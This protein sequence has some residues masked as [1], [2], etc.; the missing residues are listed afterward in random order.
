[1]RIPAPPRPLLLLTLAAALLAAGCEKIITVDLD[2]NNPQIVIEG[3]LTDAPGPCIVRVSKTGSYFSPSIVFPLVT[4]ANVTITDNTGA[5]DT[6]RE[7]DTGV[8]ASVSLRGVPGRTYTLRVAA[9]GR[10]WTAVSSMPQKA[11]IDSMYDDPSRNPKGERITNMYMLW[12][13][14]PTAGNYYRLDVRVRDGLLPDSLGNVRYRLY[15]DKFTN[16]IRAAYRVRFGRNA[17]PGDTV[18]VDL[19]AIDKAAYDYFRTLN[20]TIATDR[21]PTSLSPA[22]PVTNLTNGA[23]GFFMACTM[24][25][26]MILLK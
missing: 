6:L 18:R 1:M 8:Y 25:S 14:P 12:D 10:E 7:V 11:L 23:L 19:L 15:T 21:S 26:R 3:T 22:N 13:D 4:G 2:Q 5:I 16:G 20:T 17:M 9:E 24:D